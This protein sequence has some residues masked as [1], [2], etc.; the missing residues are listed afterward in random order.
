MRVSIEAPPGAL[1]SRASSRAGTSR[2]TYTRRG[3]AI[4]IDA[5]LVLF[6]ERLLRREE[7][8]VLVGR[9]ELI[10]L[11]GIR[12]LHLD[13]PAVAVRRIVHE[14]RFLVELVVDRHDGA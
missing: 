1:S 8:G 12:Q 10:A 2:R 13:H 3:V 9:K 4:Q 6:G 11:T 5:P 14:G 7:S